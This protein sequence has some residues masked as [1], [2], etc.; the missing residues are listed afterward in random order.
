MVKSFAIGVS[1]LVLVFLQLIKTKYFYSW[2]VFYGWPHIRDIL[3]PKPDY[4]EFDLIHDLSQTLSI[5]VK[6]NN[7]ENLYN[8]DIV[9]RECP[10]CGDDKLVGAYI[11]LAD[12]GYT[13]AAGWCAACESIVVTTDDIEIDPND[14]LDSIV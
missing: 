14:L 3:D 7:I 12:N 1:L 9:G 13:Q 5:A 11:M 2:Y 4:L 10:W 8:F 6:N